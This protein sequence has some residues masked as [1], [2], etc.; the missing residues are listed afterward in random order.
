MYIEALKWYSAFL[1]SIMWLCKAVQSMQIL[2]DSSFDDKF[3]LVFRS[4]CL[5]SMHENNY[6]AP[7]L[8]GWHVKQNGMTRMESKPKKIISPAAPR[9]TADATVLFLRLFPGTFINSLYFTPF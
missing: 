8:N 7:L 4:Y 1:Y 3:I 9:S 5:Y 6:I 2:A